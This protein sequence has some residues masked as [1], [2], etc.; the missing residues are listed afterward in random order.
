MEEM[1][2]CHITDC[3]GNTYVVKDKEAR[4]KIQELQ[5]VNEVIE[6]N[7]KPITS[8]A[9]YNSLHTLVVLLEKI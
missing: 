2:F 1:C 6:G 8:G 5:P 4:T 7:D 3:D 9:I